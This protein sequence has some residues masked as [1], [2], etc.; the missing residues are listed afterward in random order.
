MG[1]AHVTTDIIEQALI[2]LWEK[3]PKQMQRALA[4][5]KSVFDFAQ[6]NS[7]DIPRANPARWKDV[8]EHRLPLPQRT[9]KHFAAIPYKDLPAVMKL[10]RQRQRDGTGAVCIEFVILTACRSNEALG[11]RW[12]EIDWE[13]RI[14]TIPWDRA[15]AG[16]EHRVPLSDRAIQLLVQQKERTNGGPFVFTGYSQKP[17]SPGTMYGVLQGIAPGATVHGFRSSFRDWAG[18]MKTYDSET[19][20]K[21]LAHRFGT[22]VARA[23]RRG[24]DLDAR[25]E[26]MADWAKFIG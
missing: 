23:Y 20:E 6:A 1:V 2:P 13:Q 17:L 16:R 9:E 11:M 7:Y 21:A 4:V 10:V 12:D 24:D 22:K 26:L 15:K 14:W 8:L 25:R 19:I 3:H 5:W 18:D